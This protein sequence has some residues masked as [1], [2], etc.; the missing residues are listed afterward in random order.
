MQK[1]TIPF[2]S[3]IALISGVAFR[4]HVIQVVYDISD[5]SPHGLIYIV[6]PVGASC[7]AVLPLPRQVLTAGMLAS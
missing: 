7:L 2:L 5:A 4:M 6:S 1:G 3:R